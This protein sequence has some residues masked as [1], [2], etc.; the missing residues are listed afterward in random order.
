MGDMAGLKTW[1]RTDILDAILP[2]LAKG[3]SMSKILASDPA[4]LPE[5][6]T[7]WNWMQSDD[8]IL[9]RITQAREQG[10][11]KIA[12]D[13]LEIADQ[14][15]TDMVG[16]QH[17][18]L[19]IETRL[20]LLSKWHPKRYGDKLEVSGG[21]NISIESPL[22]QLRKLANG[23]NARVVEAEIIPPTIAPLVENGATEDDCF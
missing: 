6:T 10:G 8:S 3:E 22:A 15:P 18:K 20:K 21:L 14:K 12:E 19:Q 5:I 17:R 9:Q 1:N 13:C 11:D 16:V 7:L 4:R 2:R 23:R